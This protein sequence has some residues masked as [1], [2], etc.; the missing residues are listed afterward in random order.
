[1]RWVGSLTTEAGQIEPDILQISDLSQT[2]ILQT[3]IL[4]TII[5]QTII[6]QTIILLDHNP[7]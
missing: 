1:M 7:I 3:I 6:L 4:Q 5:L 2:I